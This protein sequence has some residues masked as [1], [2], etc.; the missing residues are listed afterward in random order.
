MKK[1][2]F[3]SNSIKRAQ[4]IIKKKANTSFRR[5]RRRREATGRRRSRA[6]KAGLLHLELV[7][8]LLPVH[9]NDE[10]NHQD[11]ER[12]SRD[13][14]GLSGALHELLGGDGGV[15]GHLPAL[16]DDVGVEDAGEDAVAGRSRGAQ[17]DALGG[18]HAGDILRRR[19]RRR[20]SEQS[21][22]LIKP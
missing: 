6:E 8:L 3:A 22:G 2:T 10:G 15:A 13:P 19:R 1:K 9:G 5:R 17:G 21:G 11:Q 12:R 18:G 20:R 16:V 14:C 7:E 4:C